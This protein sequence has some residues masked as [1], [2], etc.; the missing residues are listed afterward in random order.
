VEKMQ[1]NIYNGNMPYDIE[2]K[3]RLVDTSQWSGQEITNLISDVHE[4]YTNFSK[5]RA[6]PTIILHYRDLLSYLIKTY[7][8]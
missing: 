5:Q 8:H 6:N 3:Q 4:D 2:A 7:G 1:N